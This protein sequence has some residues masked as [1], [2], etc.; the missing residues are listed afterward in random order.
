MSLILSFE[1]DDLAT[2]DEVGGVTSVPTANR[3]LFE[4]CQSD[5]GYLEYL[6]RPLKSKDEY[7][8]STYILRYP[9]LKYR[10]RIKD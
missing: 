8:N 4:R 10:Y 1:E 5:A 7:I 3:A 2:I 6:E 9:I